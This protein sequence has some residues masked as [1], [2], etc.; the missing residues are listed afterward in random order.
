MMKFMEP[1]FSYP[2]N[3]IFHKNLKYYDKTI[4]PIGD[5]YYTGNAKVWSWDAF[6][7]Y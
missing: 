2:K 6:A 4:I 1:P 7:I 3:K 5:S